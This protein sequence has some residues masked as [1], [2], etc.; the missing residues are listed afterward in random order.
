MPVDYCLRN[1]Q[2]EKQFLAGWQANTLIIFSSYTVVMT[3]NIYTKREFLSKAPLP[4]RVR[5]ESLSLSKSRC[6]RSGAALT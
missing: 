4:W 3:C 6:R 2:R 1:L 5:V